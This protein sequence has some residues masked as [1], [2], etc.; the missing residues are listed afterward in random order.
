MKTK[1]TT[2]IVRL[3]AKKLPTLTDSVIDGSRT[4]GEFTVTSEIAK[5]I[6]EERNSTPADKIPSYTNR[7]LRK[8]S[9]KTNRLVMDIEEG[10]F[11]PSLLKFSTEGVLLDGQ[12]RLHA[13]SLAKKNVNM[14]V[15]TGANP[16]SMI[17]IDRGHARSDKDV[18]GLTV[19]QSE[20]W[21]LLP[22]QWSN[23]VSI[24]RRW[25]S[26]DG[27]AFQSKSQTVINQL[28]RGRSS[29]PSDQQLHK[30][31]QTN[32]ESIQFASQVI[33]YRPETRG[34]LR[35]SAL[36][37]F[38]MM[39]KIN[40]KKAKDFAHRM[41]SGGSIKGKNCASQQARKVMADI[42]KKLAKTESTYNDHL[43]LE[44]FPKLLFCAKAFLT[45]KQVLKVGT[46]NKLK[47]AN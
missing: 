16:N 45:G 31:F 9:P 18:L 24:G 22:T 27:I 26:W 42:N 43:F 29:N 38:A 35:R 46:L 11:Y 10:F 44:E 30:F 17:K 5:S 1:S 2:K 34:F 6:L 20:G 8:R 25:M 37:T 36:L 39:H 23:A 13:I 14:I 21:D 41:V 19:L 15:E 33:S 32:R 3:K 40:P 12:H 4:V 47:G 28:R 7:N